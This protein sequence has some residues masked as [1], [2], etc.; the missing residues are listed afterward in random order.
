ME[1]Q[2]LPLL[3]NREKNR[4][5]KMSRPSGTYESINLTFMPLGFQ[6]ERRKRMGWEKSILN[7]GNL[8]FDKR[9]DP[10]DSGD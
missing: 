10:T 8:K 4:L 6:K 7:G 3:N 9:H 2:K 1:Q 5:K